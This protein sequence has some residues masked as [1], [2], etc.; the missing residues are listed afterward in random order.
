MHPRLLMVQVVVQAIIDGLDR[1]E[2]VDLNL[3]TY[4][5]LTIL[6]PLNMLS[7]CLELYRCTSAALT[8]CSRS[9]DPISLPSRIEDI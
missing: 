4:S 6:G 2:V 1:G 8:W 7:S 5:L 3:T 9:T